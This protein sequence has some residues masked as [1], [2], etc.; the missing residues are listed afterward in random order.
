VGKHPPWPFLINMNRKAHRIA[1]I[2]LVLLSLVFGASDCGFFSHKQYNVLFICV[3][4]LRP[5]HL[6][7]RGYSRETSPNIDGLAEEGVVF[8]RCYSQSG[9]TLPS[10]ATIF[11][12]HY[13]KDHGAIDR[14]YAFNPELP[15]LA[16]ILAEH[17]YDTRGYV[18]HVILKPEYGFD[19]GFGVF[20]YSV[21]DVGRPEN[22]ATARQLT[23]T[24]IENIRDIQEPYFVWVHYFDPHFYY[25]S[26]PRWAH[27]GDSDVDRYD[28]EIAHTDYHIGRLLAHLEERGLDDN[29][30][31]VFTADHGEEFGEHG[32]YHHYTLFQEVLSVPLI[33][34]APFLKPG[35][36]P[37]VVEQ[38]DLLPTILAMLKIDPP[39]GCPG[40]NIFKTSGDGKGI[41]VER[42]QP[43]AFRQRGIIL[44]KYKL[45][46]ITARA[47]S[48]PRGKP[49][50]LI[51]GIFMYNLDADPGEKHNLYSEANPEANELLS[52]LNAHFAEEEIRGRRVVLDEQLRE[53]LLALGY[54]LE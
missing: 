53:R 47:A 40:K 42:D 16:S 8:P 52:V 26:H 46:T 1:L 7:Y 13:P 41:L 15:T 19:K 43:P 38:I 54:I 35:E 12:G 24:V 9:W 10:M 3:D 44:G 22:V 2:A 34:K 27:F 25:L 48:K 50:N 29:T 21:L 17:G 51:P 45:K 11:T 36:N 37:T 33:F 20:D 6:G 31:I 23:G 28:Q 49:V 5:D 18:S 30:I 4:T 39:Q 32:G 14:L